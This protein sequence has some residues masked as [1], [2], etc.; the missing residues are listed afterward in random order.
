MIGLDSNILIQLALQDHVRN[1]TTRLALNSLLNEGHNF[2]FPSSVVN[3]FLHVVTDPRRFN[4]PLSMAE[5]IAWMEELLTDPRIQLLESTAEGVLLTMAWM[6]KYNLGRKRI[7]DTHLAATLHHRGVR[8]LLT[9]N[10]DDFRIFDV[11]E[12]LTPS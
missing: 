6:K 5:A 9:S 7:L 11:F 3:E 2:G 12:L 1:G 8:R 4:P 10:P